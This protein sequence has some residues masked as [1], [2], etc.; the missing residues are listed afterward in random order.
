MRTS[1]PGKRQRLIEEGRGE[2]VI[3][4][5][6]I[7]FAHHFFTTTRPE[8]RGMFSTGTYRLA[9]ADFFA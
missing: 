9:A 8:T 5:E 4:L 7:D 1:V 3:P 6:K 2:T